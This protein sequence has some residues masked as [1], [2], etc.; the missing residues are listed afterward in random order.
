MRFGNSAHE[1][2]ERSLHQPQ[3]GCASGFQ[4]RQARNLVELFPTELRAAERHERRD[5]LVVVLG[6]SLDE[7][8]SSAGIILRERKNQRAFEA[9]ADA[10]ELSAGD[11]LASERVLD[12]AK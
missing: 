11:G 3:Q 7:A 4:R 9:L 6:E 2:A 5:Q 8:R 12:D 1:P 10:L